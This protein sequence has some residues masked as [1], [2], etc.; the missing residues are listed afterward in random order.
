MAGGH[1]DGAGKGE[2]G[3]R[4]ARFGESILGPMSGMTNRIWSLGVVPFWERRLPGTRGGAR[5]EE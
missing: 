1:A 3:I 5:V 4:G 2:G